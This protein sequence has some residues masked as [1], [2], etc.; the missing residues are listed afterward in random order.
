MAGIELA[1][2]LINDKK[3]KGKVIALGKTT[4]N[5]KYLIIKLDDDKGIIYQ[6]DFGSDIRFSNNINLEDEIVL[7]LLDEYSAEWQV[8][9]RGPEQII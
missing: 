6:I 1:K 7:K 8:N 9:K 5:Q 4:E 2:K 3:D